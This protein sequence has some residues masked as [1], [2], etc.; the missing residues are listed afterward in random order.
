MAISKHYPPLTVDQVKAYK[1][2]GPEEWRPVTRKKHYEVS[3]WGRVRSIDRYDSVNHLG[4]KVIDKFYKGQILGF[5]ETSDRYYRCLKTHVHRLVAQAFLPAPDPG[6]TVVMH[7]DDDRKHNHVSNLQW[8]SI[9]D[10]NQDMIRKGR[11]QKAKGEGHGKSTLTNEEVLNIVELS[12][13]GLSQNAISKQIGVPR[14]TI[15]GI[16]TGIRWS[17]LTGIQYKR[18]K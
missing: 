17:H 6:Q 10:N 3:N 16:L 1:K 8:G 15:G 14:Q 11:D 9:N 18:S 12:Q 4:I 7:L 2:L 5:F 13:K